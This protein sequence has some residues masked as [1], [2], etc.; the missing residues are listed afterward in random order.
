[1]TMTKKD[2]QGIWIISCVFI[3]LAIIGCFAVHFKNAAADGF[4]QETL[5]RTSGQDPVVK[6]LIDKTDP[7]TH[8]GQKRLAAVIRKIKAELVQFERLSIFIL[9]ET[10]TYS[11]TP[12]F[13]MCSPGRGDQANAMYQNPRRIQK[14]F[15]QKFETPLNDILGDLLRPGTAPQSPILEATQDLLD[16]SNTEE[17]LIIVSDMMQN[18]E[19]LSFYTHPFSLDANFQEKL[20]TMP[21]RFESIDIY[22]INRIEL[23]VSTRQKSRDFWMECTNTMAWKTRWTNL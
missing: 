2:K 7:W 8:Y 17:R 3:S 5:C 12:V 4:D 22:Y 15:E 20:C 14:K 10:G 6:L 1:M 11:P 21:H 19:A 18:S 9:D 13:D 23:P 16:S